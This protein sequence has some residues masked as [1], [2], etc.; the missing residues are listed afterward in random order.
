MFPTSEGPAIAIIDDDP[1][2]RKLLSFLIEKNNVNILFEAKN[3]LEGISLMQQSVIL[4]DLIIMDIEM[5]VMDGF[6]TA[7]ALKTHW[8]QVKII[9]HSTRVDSEAQNKI[10]TCGADYFLVKSYQSI[11]I[12]KLTMQILN[13][14]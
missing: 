2:Y 14:T 10:A 12:I 7:K 4:P 9:A 1:F 5:P 3:G 13:M 6:Q 8:P 11:E